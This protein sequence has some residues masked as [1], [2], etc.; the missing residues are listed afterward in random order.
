[1]HTYFTYFP[2]PEYPHD[3]GTSHIGTSNNDCFSTFKSLSVVRSI[4]ALRTR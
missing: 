4:T 2:N 1:M 3:S